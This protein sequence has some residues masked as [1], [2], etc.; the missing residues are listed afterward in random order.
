MR[1]QEGK[2]KR[3]LYIVRVGEYLPTGLERRLQHELRELGRRDGFFTEVV[4]LPGASLPESQP[5]KRS[6]H[7]DAE[8]ISDVL[9]QSVDE[10]KAEMGPED[11]VIGLTAARIAP[12]GEDGK[13]ASED[14]FGYY[15]NELM[16][17][18]RDNRYAVISTALWQQ[19]YDATAYRNT[20]QYTLFMVAS[21]LGD[22]YASA[23][24]SHAEFRRCMADFDDDLDSIVFSVRKA[25]L[26]ESCI[27][28]LD[29]AP[30]GLR[31][32]LEALLRKVREPTFFRVAQ[33]IKD[34]PIPSILVMGVLFSLF[35]GAL[36]K[37][38]TGSDSPVPT[39]V[40]AAVFLALFFAA[41]VVGK[42]WPMGRLG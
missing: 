18:V 15:R 24:L 32:L 23:P 1:Q 28:Q 4:L 20:F 8:K 16:P 21:F 36:G 37:V 38:I 33:A 25:R 2:P 30:L 31:E 22:R 34:S 19:K 3:R 26:C 27:R 41:L 29:A 12:P 42:L 40:S 9:R 14:C 10:A 35:M 11:S 39:A 6:L 5:G 17:Q 13:D 7:F